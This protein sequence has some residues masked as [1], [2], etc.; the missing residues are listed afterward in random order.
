MTGDG[1]D[2]IGKQNGGWT[3]TWQGTENKNT[4]FPGATSIYSG[5]ESA[6]EAIGSSSEMSADGSW[7]KKPDV[8]VVVFGEEPYAEGV[9]DIE[10]LLYK[11][12]DKS[13]LELLKTL[14]AKNIPVVAVFLT[15][16]PLW[17]NSEI[18]S[19]DAFVVAWLPG[20]EGGGIADVMVG[21]ANGQPRHDFTGKLSFDWPSAEQ[22]S[23]DKSQPV[24][25]F[26]LTRGQGLAYGGEELLVDN[27]SE[28][29][30][31]EGLSTAQIIFNGSN[32][33][34]FKSFMGDSSDWARLVEGVVAKSA[35]GDLSVTVVDGTV[36]E[37]SRLINW[38][39]KR[40]SQ[41]FWQSEDALSLSEMSDQNGAVVV[42]FKVN[43]RPMG[44]VIQR[45]DCGWPCHGSL[46][47]TNMFR[48]A[49]KGEWVTKGISLEC[50]K[51]LGVDL[52]KVTTPFLLASS[53]PFAVTIQD[54]RIMPN[55]PAELVE[56][57]VLGG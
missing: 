4:E 6:L 43:E 25:D 9:G 37:D 10:S 52:E 26:L 49:P 1:A 21:D 15:G 46:D 31:V 51:A 53:E 22:N 54:V 55:T 8:A 23:V 32:R 40:L 13:D 5:L 35:F 47:V 3:I 30:M 42:K 7:G 41:F 24:A 2:N 34:P 50:F 57:C 11:D 18:N 45:M 44:T 39:G 33:A 12:G 36:Q 14:K 28:V 48:D 16:R 19:S 38:S 27:L 29:S 20:T 17:V 56:D